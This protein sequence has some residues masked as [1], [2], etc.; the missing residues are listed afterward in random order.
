MA[1]EISNTTSNDSSKATD[2]INLFDARIK[3]FGQEAVEFFNTGL[4]G[5]VLDKAGIRFSPDDLQESTID[6]EVIVVKPGTPDFYD[7]IGQV[8]AQITTRR[9]KELAPDYTPGFDYLLAAESK[10]LEPGQQIQGIMLVGEFEELPSS[11]KDSLSLRPEVFTA[12]LGSDGA[13]IPVNVVTRTW[14]EPVTLDN[15]MVEQANGSLQ[16]AECIPGFGSINPERC[17]PILAM[18][19]GAPDGLSLNIGSSWGTTA[20]WLIGQLADRNIGSSELK[21][22]ASSVILVDPLFESGSQVIFT[23]SELLK[24][25]KEASA[26]MNSGVEGSITK[27]SKSYLPPGEFAPLLRIALESG[28]INLKSMVTTCGYN[29]NEFFGVHAEKLKEK[30]LAYVM[31]DGEH[32]I[33]GTDNKPLVTKTP[34]QSF[35][36]A[37]LNDIVNSIALLKPGGVATTD[38]NKPF[39]QTAWVALS[40]DLVV[41]MIKADPEDRNEFAKGWIRDNLDKYPLQKSLQELNKDNLE[42][43]N[44]NAIGDL[45]RFVVVGC[46]EA[47]NGQN[48]N[49]IVSF[50]R[51]QEKEVDLAI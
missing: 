25:L 37:P 13:K 17:A 46:P 19:K 11:L 1:P 47:I 5:F 21:N 39:G 26:I 49:T 16:P 31:I 3:S 32:G 33:T 36:I 30:E 9:L 44:F 22:D 45:S 48:Y 43:P 18:M 2:G 24:A 7:V 20:T 6:Q 15:V 50:V 38:D 28:S 40:V 4:I 23:N 42:L 10:Y 41:A 34:E 29:S 8:G 27:E 35:Q 51:K 12:R 14:R